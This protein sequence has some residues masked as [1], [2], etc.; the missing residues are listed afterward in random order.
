[1][2]TCLL[3][4][5]H[6]FE[7]RNMI[8]DW[9][10]WLFILKTLQAYFLTKFPYHTLSDPTKLY[11]MFPSN[12][13]FQVLTC[14]QV[15]NA[16]SNLIFFPSYTFWNNF[17]FPDNWCYL[18]VVFVNLKFYLCDNILVLVLSRRASRQLRIKWWEAFQSLNRF[19]NWTF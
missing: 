15:D 10:T 2:E 1:M 19:T 11:I 4:W 13:R 6:H 14:F 7:L 9:D 12:K 5:K 16:V 18:F 8:L 3:T 17:L